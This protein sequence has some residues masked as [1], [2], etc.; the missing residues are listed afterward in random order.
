MLD[1]Q[2]FSQNFRIVELSSCY[3][4]KNKFETTNNT[5]LLSIFGKM[6]LKV[7]V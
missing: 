5:T 1:T 2:Y 3:F 4:L 6:T 7:M